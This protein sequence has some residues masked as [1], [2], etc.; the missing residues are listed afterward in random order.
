M[1]R[2][3][4]K[5]LGKKIPYLNYL[6]GGIAYASALESARAAHDTEAASQLE[7]LMESINPLPFS[8]QDIRNAEATGVRWLNRLG[9]RTTQSR[10][11]EYLDF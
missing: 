7:A 3:A 4:A 6:F 2:N 10:F 9:N 5:R 1:W 8:Q 11:G